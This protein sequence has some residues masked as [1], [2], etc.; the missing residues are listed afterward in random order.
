FYF[1]CANL[2]LVAAGSSAGGSGTGTGGGAGGSAGSA[3]AGGTGG[4]SGS[5]ATAGMAA[6]TAAKAGA[7]AGS[8]GGRGSATAPTAK[9]QGAGCSVAYVAASNPRAAVTA[10][11]GSLFALV[12]LCSRRSPQ[13]A[14]VRR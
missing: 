10:A 4:S 9:K 2:K 6:S 1:H 7:G 3:D 12:L 8:G 14:H 11:L 13:R 5:S